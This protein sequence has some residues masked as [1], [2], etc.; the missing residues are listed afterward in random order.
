[1]TRFSQSVCELVHR[2]NTRTFRRVGRSAIVLQLLANTGSYALA[3]TTTQPRWSIAPR[4]WK[5]KIVDDVGRGPAELASTRNLRT[6]LPKLVFRSGVSRKLPTGSAFPEKALTALCRAGIEK[7]IFI[8]SPPLPA[9]SASCQRD[10]HGMR[11][12]YEQALVMRRNDAARKRVFATIHAEILA[13]EPKLILLHDFAGRH[14]AGFL[15]ALVLRQFCG[16]NGPIAQQYW[17]DTSD[18]ILVASQASILWRI[19]HFEPYPEWSLDEAQRQAHCPAEA[20][21][22]PT[23]PTKASSSS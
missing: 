10:G 9:A 4:D 16:T 12:A 23:I 20:L 11:L 17:L 21:P 8:Y 5:T 18:K 1:M 15:A 19:E 2:M 3:Q 13:P 22:H 7:V 6:V 14:A